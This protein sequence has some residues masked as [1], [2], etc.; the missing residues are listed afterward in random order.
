MGGVGGKGGAGM[1]GGAGMAGTAGGMG[2]ALE[3]GGGKG[4]A[5]KPIYFTWEQWNGQQEG[6]KGGGGYGHA[7]KRF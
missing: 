7:L 2:I 1:V 5:L 3:Q 6:G 4:D